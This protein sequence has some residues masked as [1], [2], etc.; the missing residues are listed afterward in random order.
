M[1][2]SG[3]LQSLPITGKELEELGEFLNSDEVS[4]N[5]MSIDVLEGYLTG[6]F[7]G[8]VDITP[9]D[10]L[11]YVWDITGSGE[12]HA[13][14]T[15]KKGDRII[16]LIMLFSSSISLILTRNPEAYMPLLEC[17]EFEDPVD[18][19]L[20]VK[21]WVVGFMLAITHNMKAWKPLMFSER[22]MMILAPILSTAEAEGNGEQVDQAEWDFCREMITPTVF[23]VYTFWQQYREQG[24]QMTGTVRKGELAGRNDPC[25]C[26]SGK[27]YKKCCGG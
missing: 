10:W 17:T 25:P 2:E 5:T 22:M 27:K 20:A 23:A 6:M 12:V 9:G 24:G 19:Q 1:M 26:G 15:K 18:E 7:I 11:P 8:P 21:S 16:R 14:S 4:E 13:F 3:G